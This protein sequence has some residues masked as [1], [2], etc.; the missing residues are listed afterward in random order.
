MEKNQGVTRKGNQDTF[1][2]QVLHFDRSLDYIDASIYQNSEMVH[3][4]L[5]HFS[6]EKN[7]TEL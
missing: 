3:L 5:V 1:L 6:K 2:V 4:E 7:N